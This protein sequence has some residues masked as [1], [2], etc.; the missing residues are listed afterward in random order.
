MEIVPPFPRASPGVTT[1]LDGY[2]AIIVG[3]GAGIDTPLPK[4][5]PPFAPWT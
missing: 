5:T 1:T 4:L 3:G 2:G